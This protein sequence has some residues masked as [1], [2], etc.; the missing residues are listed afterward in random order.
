MKDT[1]KLI[2]IIIISCC[3]VL[4]CTMFMNYYMD[5]TGVRE[6]I[7]SEQVMVFYEAQVS[8]AKIVCAV[9][10][11]CLLVTSVIMLLFYIRHYIDT[12]K[13]EL[14]ILKALGYSKLKIAGNFW[15]F[16]SSVL[17]GT[18]L[19]FAGAFC[20]MPAFYRVQNED[21]LLPEMAVGFHPSLLLYLVA[22]PAAAFALLAVGYAW[23]R[24]K[25]PVMSLLRNDASGCAGAGRHREKAVDG[26][27]CDGKSGGSFLEDLRRNTLRDKKV[28]AFFI[29]FAS[30]CFS[31]MTQ[32]SFSMKD[33]A[34][35]MM[36]AMIL[37]I[38]LVL[39]CTTLFLAITTVINGNR[40]TIAMM[41]VFGY[42][43][44]ECSG[45]ILGGYRPVSYVGFAV[46]TVY[47]YALLRIMV[48]IVF[49]DVE[50]VPVYEFDFP[51]MLVSLG[52]FIL[53]Y[54][55]VMYAC[56]E[57][58]KKISVKEIMLE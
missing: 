42:S 56:S 31:A 18:A 39:A 14:G 19:G 12:H 24:L 30:F 9:S 50:G 55:T 54:E 22:A 33:L 20:M 28:L 16:G 36:G 11:G 7:V 13:K 45:A 15:V 43:G 10:G 17:I 46:G 44:Q 6:E 35:P 5:V 3:M 27:C 37:L 8:T 21:K 29:L 32:M 38:G 1:A 47:Q 48:G 26:Q 51:V 2:G 40:K 49:R 58:I 53:V 25:M 52:V 34:S 41:R 57:R 23:Y 4:V